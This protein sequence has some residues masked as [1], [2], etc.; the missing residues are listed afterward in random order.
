MTIH[1]LIADDLR[2]RYSFSGLAFDVMKESSNAMKH[3]VQCN[4][5]VIGWNER[6]IRRDEI[7][8]GRDERAIRRDERDV[9]RNERAIG[10]N[11]RDIQ[12]T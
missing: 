12:R 8:V 4:E 10:R 11:E 7:D 6:V 5:K 9:G 3:I 2:D 1:K